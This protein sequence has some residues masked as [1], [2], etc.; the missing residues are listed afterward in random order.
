M[1]YTAGGSKGEVKKLGIPHPR[2][3]NY[4]M[5]NF[6]LMYKRR[7]FQFYKMKSSR[8]GWMMATQ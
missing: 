2:S 3:L 4:I 7:E 5:K 6:F 8:D 1:R